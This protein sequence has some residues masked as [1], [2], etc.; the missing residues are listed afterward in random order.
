MKHADLAARRQEFPDRFAQNPLTCAM[1]DLQLLFTVQQSLVEESAEQTLGILDPLA[2]QDQARQ[3][4]LALNPVADLWRRLS[5][6]GK[7]TGLELSKGLPRLAQL[8]A[9]GLQFDP[10]TVN[11]SHFSFHAKG[12]QI[13]E[14]SDRD[15]FR[16]PLGALRQGLRQTF[17]ERPHSSGQFSTLPRHDSLLWHLAENLLQL[18]FCSRENLY[19]LLPRIFEY[20]PTPGI[21][22]FAIIMDAVLLSLRRGPQA[23][24]PM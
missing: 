17:A 21:E 3:K 14:L 20:L 9:T 2:D 13:K 10:V 7:P 11:M 8:F 19:P 12:R 15:L 24:G 4:S 16:D 6:F 22:C 23:P 5:L 1:D 18:F